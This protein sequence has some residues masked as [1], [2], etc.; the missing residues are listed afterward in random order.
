M[1]ENKI[2]SLNNQTVQTFQIKTK[3]FKPQDKHFNVCIRYTWG[4]RFPSQN[5]YTNNGKQI[6]IYL[7]IEL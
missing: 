7:S 2:N 3:V 4:R 6:F 5:S 1:S